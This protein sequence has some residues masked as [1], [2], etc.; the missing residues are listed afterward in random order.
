MGA[1]SNGG[2]QRA[3]GNGWWHRRADGLWY[4]EGTDATYIGVNK[5]FSDVIARF[6]D[7]KQSSA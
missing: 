1:A 4:D 3:G 7:K 6:M 2:H 5:A